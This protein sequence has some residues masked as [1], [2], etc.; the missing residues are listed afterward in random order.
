MRAAGRPCA[1]ASTSVDN[2]DLRLRLLQLVTLLGSA[3]FLITEVLGCF[4]RIQR[5]PLIVAWLV[6]A[7]CA[8]VI[9]RTRWTPLRI[10]WRSADPV[11]LLCA[12]GCLG[13]AGITAATA[14]LSPPNSADAMAYHL[15]RV[16]Y[17][18][19]QASVRFFPT[20][21]LN[22]IMLQPF[23]EYV[24][25]HTY[26]I[27]GGDRLVNLV[28]WLASVVSVVGVSY[29]AGL[30]GIGSRGQAMAALF[31]ASLPS[32][33]LAGSG[34]KN[35]WVLAMWMVIAVSFALRFASTHRMGDALLLG[36]AGGLALL[37][38]ATAYLFLPWLI[39]AA[40]LARWRPGLRS[41]AAG[42]A[43]ALCAL[44]INAPHFIRNHRLSGSVLG[45][46]SAQA[47][48]FFRWRN[49]TFGWKQTASNAA[50]HLSEQLGARSERWNRGVFE[51]VLALHRRLGIDPNDPATT[52]RWTR[53]GPPRN[54]NHEADAPNRWHLALLA[55]IAAVLAWRALRGS[56]RAPALYLAAVL[57]AFL[58]FSAYLKW[59]P[60]MARLLL[61]LY[62]AAAPVA[63]F[64]GEMRPALRALLLQLPLCL[65]L[66]DNARLP[67]LQN[68]T[69]PLRG[70]ESILHAERELQ[71]FA[72][73]RPWNN[74]DSY[75]RTADFIAR[76]GCDT[77]GIDIHRLHL[78]YPLMALV[79]RRKPAAR[80]LHTAVTNPSRSCRP[81]VGSP[82]CLVAC[83]DCAG[84]PARLGLYA[85]FPQSAVFGRFV[86]LSK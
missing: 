38:K 39:A 25:L 76:A 26:V 78:E 15:P 58:A 44:A 80:F 30:F 9:L 49:E 50:R 41:A 72:D 75:L 29:A 56:G 46:D 31:C 68:W 13:I 77:V 42:A 35:D 83:L 34:A 67:L 16:V 65:F 6:V 36:A 28:A 27:S 40:L 10:P 7:V 19:E 53:F 22:Q 73:L 37:T 59:Q 18:S 79:R 63:G 11:I 52:W 74:R 55:A 69:R 66:L 21:Y 84:D 12:A 32:G 43:A 45:F 2:V 71:Y 51:A 8:A 86:V 23:A 20:P 48:G 64:A 33:I 60:F 3:L 61:P 4:E 17:W 85:G 54:A 5:G 70:P 47:D 1:A 82:P 62:I 14:I 57:C 24:M 81:P